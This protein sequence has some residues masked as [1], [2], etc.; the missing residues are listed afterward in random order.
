LI[1][2]LDRY[3]TKEIITPFLFGLMAFSF[4]LLGS[5][6]LF[7]LIGEAIKYNIPW[8]YVTQLFIYKS[9]GIIVFTFPMTMLLAAILT[10]GRLSSDLEITGFRAAGIGIYRLVI[11]VAI[12]GFMVSCLTI[13]FNEGIVPQ[14]NFK[15]EQ[16]IKTFQAQDIPKIKK[17]IN[18]TEYD[19]QG[20]PLRIINVMEIE[21]S[22]LRNITVAEYESGF[23]ARLIRA[24]SGRWLETG[25]WE[26]FNGIMHTFSLLSPKKVTVIEFQK[27]FINIQLNPLQL[28][29]RE[30]ATTEMSAKELRMRIELLKQTGRDPTKDWV[31]FHLKFSV[32]F[33]CLIFSI[34][35]AAVGLRPHRS[36]SALGLG[37]SLV[38]ILIY[39]ILLSVGMGLGLSGIVSPLAAAWTPNI[40]VGIAALYLLNKVASQ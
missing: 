19:K 10:F 39:Y 25:G 29:E 23:L 11:P 3:I 6:V 5:T 31:E 30:K 16:L 32:P 40:I 18:V 4:I 1:R 2:I 17:N 37:I 34:L 27:E 14:A 7:P 36:S 13:L 33:A 26:F 35:G 28:A 8:K 9:P 15:A 22:I 21:E 12:L 38:I 24:Q 20:N